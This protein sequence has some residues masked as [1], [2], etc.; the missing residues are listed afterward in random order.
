MWGVAYRIQASKVDEVRAY[1]DIREINGY[2]IDHTM[3]WP[4]DD[5]LPPV[6]TLLY[7]GTPDNAQFVGPQDAQQLAD[8]IGGSRGPSGENAEYL[9]M[10]DDALERLC[11]QS[12]D[13][14]VRDLAGRVRATQEAA[15]RRETG[16]ARGDGAAE[17]EDAEK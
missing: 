13:E 5:A 6:R 15:A 10:M 3:F 12:R 11:P 14:H 4:A 7:I 9:L 1:L 8:H 17:Q 2:S 16:G